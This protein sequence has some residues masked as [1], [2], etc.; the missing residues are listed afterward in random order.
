MPLSRRGKILKLAWVGAQLLIPMRGVI[1]TGLQTHITTMESYRFSWNMMMHS[2]TASI[3]PGMHMARLFPQ[4]DGNKF[5]NPMETPLLSP[6]EVPYMC[7]MAP[8]LVCSVPRSRHRCARCMCVP[9]SFQ[10]L[11]SRGALIWAVLL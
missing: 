3:R 10:I 4:C 2:K 1:F 11:Q 8:I 6:N 9:L 7:A 5:P